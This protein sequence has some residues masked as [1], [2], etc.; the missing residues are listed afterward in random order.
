MI[1]RGRFTP[2]RRA[3]LVL[4]LLALGWLGW[5]WY[6]G[7][8][9]T[10]GVEKEQMDWNGDGQVSREEFFQAFYAVTVKD[11]QEGNR[12]CRSFLWRRNGEEFRRD[13]KTV[14]KADDASQSGATP[15]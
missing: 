4:V 9:I 7:I 15:R 11:L 3:L 14:F 1:L 8:A 5:A 2:R 12:H 6:A 10:R 13:C